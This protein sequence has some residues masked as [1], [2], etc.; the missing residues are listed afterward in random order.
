MHFQK[1]L[2]SRWGGGEKWVTGRV[3][4]QARWMWTALIRCWVGKAS[5]DVFEQGGGCIGWLCRTSLPRPHTH[6]PHPAAALDEGRG[7]TEPH[8]SH[9]H[10]PSRYPTTL[11]PPCACV[12]LPL[13]FSRIPTPLIHSPF[14]PTLCLHAVQP[15]LCRGDAKDDPTHHPFAV[16]HPNSTDHTL[17]I[18]PV[19]CAQF[20]QDF[21]EEMR[22]V[23]QQMKEQ[24]ASRLKK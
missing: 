1:M 2:C 24:E 4:L 19:A 22:K 6:S 5:G 11:T 12:P 15:G 18:S 20:R 7:L 10:T 3:W 21:A 16:L 13:P 9:T 23:Q 17:S 8:F 14:H